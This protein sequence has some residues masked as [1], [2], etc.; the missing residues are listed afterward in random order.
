MAA[1]IPAFSAS[2]A[3]AGKMPALLEAGASRM[4]ASR[5]PKNPSFFAPSA[6]HEPSLTGRVRHQSQASFSQTQIPRFPECCKFKC[7]MRLVFSFSL[8]AGGLTASFAITKVCGKPRKP[9]HENAQ[10]SSTD[11]EVAPRGVGTRVGHRMFS[12]SQLGGAQTDAWRFQPFG[13]APDEFR[14]RGWIGSA[15]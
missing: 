14:A 10:R 13:R 1:S 4:P 8:P 6:R 12:G 7:A 2:L 3:N 9:S 5:S 11:Q 15:A